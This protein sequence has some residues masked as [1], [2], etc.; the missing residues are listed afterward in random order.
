MKT[1]E[2]LI[3]HIITPQVQQAQDPLQFSYQRNVGVEDAL[4]YLLHH[5]LTYLNGKVAL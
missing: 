5:A 3:L 4:L 2:R 1:L